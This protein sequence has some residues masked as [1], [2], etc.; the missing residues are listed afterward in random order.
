MIFINKFLTRNILLHKIIL[1]NKFPTRNNLLHNLNI[2]LTNSY[3]FLT[4]NILLHT[5]IL[6][7]KFPTRYITLH[8]ILNNMC[9]F[10]LILTNFLLG[11]IYYKNLNINL[12]NSY[13]FITRNILL[14]KIILIKKFST[15]YITLHIS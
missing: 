13:K 10:Y 3:K 6:I 14:H 1:I 9:K 15:R 5:I 8:H 12:P 2:N 11:I 4:R 7:N